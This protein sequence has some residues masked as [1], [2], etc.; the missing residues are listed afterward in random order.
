MRCQC[1]F[2]SR[3]ISRL[4]AEVRVFKPVALFSDNDWAASRGGNGLRIPKRLKVRISVTSNRRRKRIE[5]FII[6]SP[7]LS[8]DRVSL[9]RGFMPEKKYLH[10]P[11]RVYHVSFEGKKKNT[12]FLDHYSSVAIKCNCPSITFDRENFSQDLVR[13]YGEVVCLKGIT[14][15]IKDEGRGSRVE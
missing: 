12:R 1:P 4:A 6:I 8:I 14:T 10:L 13:H 7:L 15:G 5:I 11:Q 2:A 9:K 3:P